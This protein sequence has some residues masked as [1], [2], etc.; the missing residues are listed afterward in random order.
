MTRFDILEVARNSIRDREN[1]YGSPVVNY[2]RLAG[3][4]TI[5]LKDKLRSGETISSAD[6][7][8][9]MCGVKIARL[10]NQPDHADSQADLAG[11]AAILS[12][13]A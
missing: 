3:L 9:V 11:Y 1:Q 12:E 8:I 2:K 4:M 7:I 10:I 5:I 6:A 13:V